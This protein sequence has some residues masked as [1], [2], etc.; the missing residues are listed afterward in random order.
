MPVFK[1]WL[2]VQFRTKANL[3]SV[4]RHIVVW[5]VNA[6]VPVVGRGDRAP[7]VRFWFMVLCRGMS[8][9]KG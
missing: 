2:A 6:L 9:E 1:A 4:V 7:V 8:N 5:R 3:A